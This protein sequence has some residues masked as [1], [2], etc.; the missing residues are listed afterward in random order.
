ML[1]LTFVLVALLIGCSKDA[2]VL[3]VFRFVAAGSRSVFAQTTEQFPVEYDSTTAG[4]FIKSING[5]SQSK[6]A[7]WLYYINGKSAL[8]SADAV[9]PIAGDTIEW[10][11]SAG[12]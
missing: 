6:T 11:L 8:R 3:E 12:Y 5:V 4:V 7:Y 1:T 10:R 9:I 2:K